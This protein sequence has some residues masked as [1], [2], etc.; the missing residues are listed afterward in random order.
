MKNATVT[1]AP[2]TLRELSDV[3]CSAAKRAGQWIAARRPKT[4]EHKEGALHLA[5]QV[6]TEVDRQ[7]EE[8]L[9]ECLRESTAQYDFALL[10]E[11]SPDDGARLEKEFFWCVDP[12]DGTLPYI[13]N[14]PGYSVVIS[15]IRRDGV[16][17]LGVVYDPLSDTMYSA[18]HGVVEVA[19]PRPFSNEELLSV[20]FDRSFLGDENYS[21]VHARLEE[22]SETMGLGGVLVHVGAGAAMNACWAISRSPSCYFK[23]PKEGEGGGCLWDFAASACLYRASGLIATDI[24]GNALDLNRADSCFMNH[25]GVLFASDARIAQEIRLLYRDLS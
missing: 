11:E 8:I 19:R 4:I 15:L 14:E 6:V 7:S 1:L 13:E 5:S 16:P 12:L 24:F 23:F 22:L 10:T 2:A 20:Y 21:Q 17:M 25:R 3:A 9:V 18:I